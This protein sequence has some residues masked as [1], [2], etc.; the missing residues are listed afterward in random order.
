M[1]LQRQSADLCFL[2]LQYFRLDAGACLEYIGLSP[3][4]PQQYADNR[5]PLVR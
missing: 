4:R 5:L 2:T 3:I 1:N